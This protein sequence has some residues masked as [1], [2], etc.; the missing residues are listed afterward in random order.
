MFSPS[1]WNFF[2]NVLE[3]FPCCKIAKY[4]HFLAVRELFP[5]STFHRQLVAGFY[6]L[7]YAV[8]IC[9]MRE[10]GFSGEAIR[11]VSIDECFSNY[12]ASSDNI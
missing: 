9:L 11:T 5:L 2:L 7:F 8:S 6:I 10:R 3:M 1:D 12:P 4:F